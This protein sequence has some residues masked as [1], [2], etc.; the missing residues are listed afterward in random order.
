MLLL[1]VWAIQLLA[2]LYTKMLFSRIIKN[3]EDCEDLIDVSMVS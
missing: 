3:A 1:G 2:E